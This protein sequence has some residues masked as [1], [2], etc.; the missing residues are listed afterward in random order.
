MIPR[1]STDDLLGVDT[2]LVNDARLVP[3]FNQLGA[4]RDALCADLMTLYREWF[5]M[6]FEVSALRCEEHRFQG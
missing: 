4:H 5:G 3:A 6:R 1:H 2:G